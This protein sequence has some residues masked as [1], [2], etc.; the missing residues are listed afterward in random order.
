[1]LENAAGGILFIADLMLLGK[2]QQKNLVY[3]LERLEKNNLQLIVACP[4][5]LTALVDAG[6]DSA[7]VTRLGEVRGDAA[8]AF[9]P[10]R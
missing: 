2:L 10:R 1:M 9:R 4:R 5:A 3:A 7:L 6:W 8:A